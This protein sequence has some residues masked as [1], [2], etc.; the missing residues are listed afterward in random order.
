MH[1]WPLATRVLIAVGGKGD[2]HVPLYQE[3]HTF[4]GS[5]LVIRVG[6]GQKEVKYQQWRAS[7]MQHICYFALDK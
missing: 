5:Q 4:W 3:V 6:G 2:S 7:A 1:P